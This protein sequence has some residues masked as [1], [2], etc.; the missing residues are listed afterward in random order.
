MLV[1]LVSIDKGPIW[2]SGLNIVAV[3]TD[4]IVGRGG[5]S[6]SSQLGRVSGTCRACS[7][8]HVCACA[9]VVEQAGCRSSRGGS[10]GEGGSCWDDKGWESGRCR[11]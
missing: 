11:C 5:R 8:S 7:R 1:R 2:L 10:S 9:C 6:R 3:W 4:M